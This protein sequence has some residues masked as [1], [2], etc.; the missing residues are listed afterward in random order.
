M[1]FELV[2]EV[3]QREWRLPEIRLRDGP[4][5]SIRI[6][7]VDAGKG[8]LIIF[9]QKRTPSFSRLTNPAR[10]PNSGRSISGYWFVPATRR[11]VF[12]DIK[13]WKMSECFFQ[14]AGGKLGDGYKGHGGK[15]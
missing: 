6:A 10:C 4:V 14:S 7:Q 11:E 12:E 8:L 13:G 1:S 15:M 9:H 3:P 2:L 5:L